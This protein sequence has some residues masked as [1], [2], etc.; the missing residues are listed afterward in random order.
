MHL[1]TLE[2]PS[3]SSTEVSAIR[4]AKT[5]WKARNKIKVH[6]S[7]MKSQ[8]IKTPTTANIDQ[9]LKF[10]F[11]FLPCISKVSS[12]NIKFLWCP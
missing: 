12:F 9:Q 7:S 2:N 5:R 3:A 1:K 10:H 6:L 8:N 4:E 11:P